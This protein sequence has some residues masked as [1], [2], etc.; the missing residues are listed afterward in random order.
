MDWSYLDKIDKNLLYIYARG[1][2]KKSNEVHY[3]GMYSTEKTENDE[4][5][6]FINAELKRKTAFYIIWFVFRY[7]LNCKTLEEA[8]QCAT[9]ENLR[10]FKLVSLFHK[11]HI[12]IGVYGMQE[13][14]LYKYKEEDIG[15]VLEILYN[16]YDF[17][18]QLKCFTRRTQGTTR[19]TCNRCQRAIE[20]YKKMMQGKPEY[21]NI[22]KELS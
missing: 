15:V 12:Y 17:F 14:Y 3:Q 13:I 9:E 11:R 5:N 20:Q 19:T 6:K 18:N 8:E 21:E 1:L 10:K 22:L 2:T 7:V 16:R 4:R